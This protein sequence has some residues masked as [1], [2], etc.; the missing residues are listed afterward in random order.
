MDRAELLEGLRDAAPAVPPL[1]TGGMIF[2][3]TAVQTGFTPLSATLLSLFAFAG[4]AQ[5][6]ALEL[7]EDGAVVHVV[8]GT[9]FLI[10]LRYVVFSASLAPK[11]SHLSRTWRVVVAYP[12]SDINYALAEVRFTDDDIDEGHRGWYLVGTSVPLVAGLTVGT[13]TGALLGRVIGEG[14]HLDFAVTLV[15]VSL[16][17]SQIEERA[18]AVGAA[19]G[20]VVAT[21][22]AGLPANLGLLAAVVLGTALGV[23]AARQF[24]R[25]EP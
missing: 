13:L 22:G 3:V 11:I 8:L 18:T 21:A 1:V 6:A 17:A 14:L 2:G 5:L 25:T 20:V 23:L 19:A 15:F 16:L 10:N 12:L 7:L 24:G 4:T 9:V